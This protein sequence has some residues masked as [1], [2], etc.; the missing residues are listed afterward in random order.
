MTPVAV[1]A[2]FG[3]CCMIGC[4]DR[5]DRYEGGT[6]P[7]GPVRERHEWGIAKMGTT[8]LQVVQWIKKSDMVQADVG[9][10]LTVAPIGSNPC[11]CAFTDGCH[12]DVFLEVVGQKG[13]GRFEM[14][15]A[16]TD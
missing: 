10:V 14:G 4:L 8:Y 5:N 11:L 3:A 16:F 12:C 1:A 9:E 6:A 13:S 7:G 15:S 2:L